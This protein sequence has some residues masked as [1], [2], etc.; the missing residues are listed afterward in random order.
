MIVGTKWCG[1]GDIAKNYFDIG[2]LWHVDVCCRAHD[3][4]PY[5]MKALR[6]GYGLLNLSFYTRLVNSAMFSP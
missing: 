4:C 2:R 6:Y 1:L 5:R 3:H